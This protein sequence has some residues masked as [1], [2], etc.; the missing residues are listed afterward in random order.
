MN[1]RDTIIAPA[2]PVGNSG[3][4]IVRISGSASFSFLQRH[5]LAHS[6]ASRFKSHQ[7]YLGK[8]VDSAEDVVDEVMA[9]HMHA[10][11]TYTCEDV[12]EIHCHGS[13]QV[14][15]AILDLAIAHGIRLAKPGEFTY[16]A[17]LNGR[18]DLTQA[19]A[20]SRLI[21]SKS[22]YSRKAALQQLDGLLSRRIHSFS[23]QLK[24]VLVMLEAWID[25]PEEDLPEE[26]IE[27][28][29]QSTKLLLADMESLANSFRV[30]QRVHD[31][32]TVVLVGLP[33]VG[34]SS[35]LNAFLEEE[36]AIVSA[37]PGTTRDL[38]EQSVDMAGLTVRLVDTAGL[39]E[40]NDYVEREGVRRAQEKLKT[41]DL[42]LLLMD[43]TERP[44]QE[45]LSLFQLCKPH[46]TVLVLTKSDLS[47]ASQKAETSFF[48]GPIF[49]VSAKSG[50][51]LDDLRQ[52]IVESLYKDHI[53]DAEPTYLTER[54]H[55]EALVCANSSVRIFLNNMNQ[56]PVD[57]LAIDLRDALH[58][59]AA[60]TGEVTTNSILD[61]VFSQF[62]IG[63]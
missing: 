37:I 11:R 4:A 17:Y 42:V 58:H 46:P 54:R 21:H 5:F 9:V 14:V 59:L 22:E 29:R 50:E 41:A 23:S 25:F 16:R 19:E 43:S 31:G 48:S 47:V 15:K 45:F 52:H 30:G 51:G 1:D 55:F 3:I 32:V 10:P 36:R 49:S 2:T 35:L 34:K 61:D 7:L 26:N 6:G 62:C 28:I 63:K 60:I 44:C 13:R 38:I 24:D 53:P 57:L 20:V 18:L 39:R 12:V 27:H 40:A 56:T 33:N 8:L